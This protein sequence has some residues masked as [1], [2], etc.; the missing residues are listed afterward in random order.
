MHFGA[1]W[2]IGRNLSKN[3]LGDIALKNR[4]IAPWMRRIGRVSIIYLSTDNKIQM[5]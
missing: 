4:L 1:S 2:E 3:Y 5:E